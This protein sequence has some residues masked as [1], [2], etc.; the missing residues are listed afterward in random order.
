[1]AAS[2][3]T[4]RKQVRAFNEDLLEDMLRL[5]SLSGLAAEDRG[6]RKRTLAEIESLLGLVDAC[7]GKVAG[8]SKNLETKLESPS[9]EDGAGAPAMVDDEE[10]TSSTDSS[11]DVDDVQGGCAPLVASSPSRSPRTDLRWAGVLPPPRRELWQKMHLPLQFRSREVQGGWEIFASVPG[12]DANDI[13]VKVGEDGSRVTIS[14][15]RLPSEQHSRRMCSDLSDLLQQHAR[16]SP[17]LLQ[18]LHGRRLGE[19]AD[20]AYADMGRGKFGAF[21]ESFA[22]PR[23]ADTSRLRATYRDGVLRVFL[24]RKV[25]ASRPLSARS[26]FFDDMM[27]GW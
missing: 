17:A 24:P 12:L 2:A 3:E 6:G 5:D 11:S 14:G 21:G 20:R 18:E 1:M 7:S 8:L 16:R 27:W 19:L 26:P 25:R 10:S 23:D 15:V 9:R 13:K 4:A 22:L